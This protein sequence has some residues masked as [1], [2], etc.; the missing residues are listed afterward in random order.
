VNGLLTITAGELDVS[1]SDFAITAAAGWTDTGSGT[2]TERAATVTFDGTGTVNSN[3]AFYRVTV[4]A[5]GGTVTLG[6]A[7]DADGLITITDGA[8][9]VS[10]SNYSI[11]AA[12]GWTDTGSG[13]FTER[14]G[15]VTFDGTGSIN[16]ND[17][18]NNLVIN[19]SG[20]IVSLTGN[21]NVDGDLTITLGSLSPDSYTI[22]VGGSWTKVD[23]A[24]FT[25]GTS[26]VTFDDVSKTSVV[27]GDTSFNSFTSTTAGKNI[28]FTAG[29]TQTIAS[30]TLTGT[31]GNLITLRSSS[32]GTVWNTNI[33]SGTVS[34]ADVKDGNNT[35][36]DTTTSNS[37]DS[38]NNTSWGFNV[39][40]VVSVTSVAQKTDGTGV[41]DFAFTVSDGDADSTSVKLEY[42]IDGGA[43]WSAGNVSPAAGTG[44]ISVGPTPTINN[45]TAYQMAGFGTSSPNNVTGQWRSVRDVLPTTDVSGAQLRFTANDSTV[46]SSV[47]TSSAFVLDIVNPTGLANLRSSKNSTTSK[48]ASLVWDAASDSNFDHYEIWYSKDVEEVNSRSATN[49]E[50]YDNDSNESL[51]TASNASIDISMTPDG[52]Y[53][54]IW[55]V[56]AYGYELSTDE[57]F[58]SVSDGGTS[59]ISQTF[60]PRN[61]IRS[62]DV[63]A[64][65]GE[66][67][68]ET[69]IA[70]SIYNGSITRIS[71]DFRATDAR[72]TVG[73]SFGGT[74]DEFSSP[75]IP[76]T[77]ER[78]EAPESHWS[79]NYLNDL[80]NKDEVVQAVASTISFYEMVFE[81]FLAPDDGMSRGAGVQLLVVLS[82]FEVDTDSLV[83]D[84]F[85]DLSPFDERDHF[86]QFAHDEGKITGYPDGSFKSEDILNRVEALKIISEFFSHEIAYDYSG[87]DLLDLYGLTENPFTDLDLNLWF[88]PYVIH[89]WEFQAL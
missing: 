21:L 6:A 26:T 67:A 51:A 36:T 87:Q 14:A 9:D 18:F 60:I 37:T 8:L 73:S 24:T 85:T 75:D 82:G 86:L 1:A 28:T 64:I 42:S 47:A 38:G 89:R 23:G 80:I 57:I 65:A 71:D 76:D 39:A 29:D 7:L 12:N 74:N 44:T 10:A 46:D 83:L 3:E 55:A 56:D 2:F 77:I 16:S 49:A 30:L 41:V 48:N 35:G 63:H 27:D 34:Y 15:A 31:S 33:T 11:T 54:K 20:K 25:A 69:P 45:N 5:S 88:A 4:N 78:L 52:Y 40:P 61:N 13:T 66:P 72:S 68:I 79:K 81:M 43:T 84:A 17:A 70:G 58:I 62:L 19:A 22:T 53:F 32:G 59:I 50:E